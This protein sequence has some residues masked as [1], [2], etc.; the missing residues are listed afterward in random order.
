MAEHTAGAQLYVG[1]DIAA[2]TFTAE[3]KFALRTLLRQPQTGGDPIEALR[4]LNRYMTDSQRLDGKATDIF[5]C[6]VAAVLD[7]ASGYVMLGL[8][9]MEPPLVLRAGTDET[10]TIA[11][12]GTMLGMSPEWHGDAVSFRLNPGDLLLLFSDGL[13]EVRREGE[14]FDFF[15]PD[16]VARAAR[17]ALTRSATLPA[18]GRAIVEA[19]RSFG[20]RPVSDDVCL[21]LTRL[22]APT[23]T[24]PQV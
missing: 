6:V 12:G 20:G 22:K 5:V 4:A 23:L 24:L 11:L 7:P 9:G 18:V 15:G 21:L 10:E 2:A 8:A 19:A 16:G 3:I 13:T 14:R 17:E 1:I